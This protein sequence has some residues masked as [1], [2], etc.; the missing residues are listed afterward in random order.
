MSPVVAA[1]VDGL[2]ELVDDAQREARLLVG[3]VVWFF[4]HGCIL[5]NE[6]VVVGGIDGVAVRYRFGFASGEGV[7]EP[8]GG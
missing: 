1:V 6:Q 5:E 8:D 4:E 2:V 7:A 3:V